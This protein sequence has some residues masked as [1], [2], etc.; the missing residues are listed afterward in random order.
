MCIRDRNG[1]L[2]KLR[3][4]NRHDIHPVTGR[5]ITPELV[6]KDVRL[7]KEANINFCLLYTSRCV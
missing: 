2:L 7:F 4:I 5:A 6:E 1:D 3:G